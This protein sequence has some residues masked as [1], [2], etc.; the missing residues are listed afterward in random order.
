MAQN[1]EESKSQAGT[2]NTN[3]T[4]NLDGKNEQTNFWSNSDMLS[5]DF[6][7]LNVGEDALNFLSAPSPSMNSEKNIPSPSLFQPNA[8]PSIPQS[9]A[10]TPTGSGTTKQDQ[11][12]QNF[13]LSHYQN[14]LS[15]SKVPMKQATSPLSY[16]SPNTGQSGASQVQNPTGSVSPANNVPIN[17]PLHP[18]NIQK[19]LQQQPKQSPFQPPQSLFQENNGTKGNNNPC[20]H[21][22]RRQIKCITVPNLINCVQCETKGIKCTHSES[23]S[24]PTLKRNMGMVTNANVADSNNNNNKRPRLSPQTSGSSFSQ[25]IPTQSN[26]LTKQNLRKQ[27]QTPQSQ[28]PPTLQYPRSSFF[29]GSS[30]MYDNSILDR[31]RLD[32]IDQVQLSPSLSLRKVSNDVQFILR[33]DY[34]DELA[35]KA[36]K[37]VDAVENIVSPHGQSLINTYFRIIH[38]S[39]P[40]L[41]RKVFL[42][43]YSRS[44]REFSAPLLASVYYLAIQ[45]WD[46]D[47][48]LSQYPKPDLKLLYEI[49]LKSFSEV[50]DRPRLSAVQAGLLILQCRSENEN[51]WIL[52]QQVVSLAEELGLGLD[53]QNW[54]LPK[55]ERGLRRRLAWAVWIQEKWTALIESRVSHFV[56]GRN[57]L[58]R[59]VTEEDFPEHPVRRTNQSDED[60]KS[61]IDDIE[62]GKYLFKETIELSL[63][64]GE[65]LETF[66]SYNALQNITKVEQ[67]LKLAKPLQLQL[68]QWY[69]SLPTTLHMTSVKN[70]KL[71][72]NAYL[73]LSYFATEILLHRKIISSLNEETPPELIKVCRT[74]ATTRLTAVIDFVKSLR[75]EHVYAFWNSPTSS[76]FTIV[77]TFAAILYVTSPTA[78]EAQ[79]FR[80]HTS[81]YRLLLYKLGKFSK[82]AF[83]AL[84]R[85]DMLL[86]HIPGLIKEISTDQSP[87]SNVSQSP[88]SNFQSLSPMLTQHM[89]SNLPNIG[90]MPNNL[91]N[92]NNGG[93]RRNGPPVTT[94][95]NEVD[96][97]Q[98]PSG[99][100]ETGSRG[101][102]TPLQTGIPR[103]NANSPVDV[104]VG[105]SGTTPK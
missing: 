51:N 8:A 12:H 48:S 6:N 20:D 79:Q 58:V 99:L 66:Y 72:S 47:P 16:T 25:R 75:R 21:C 96:N 42:E 29:V 13:M 65:I 11:Q 45:W 49:A 77:G 59:N 23:P 5:P 64:M 88:N 105:T 69:H 46:Q 1:P 70:G 100:S 35:S 52:C 91:P 26:N 2:P 32:K 104:R 97:K 44:Y 18:E 14:L 102:P 57:W 68:R 84:K 39:F 54:K 30:S 85:I 3:I 38:P 82:N 56:L 90:N 60:Y 4:L 53:C 41:H 19:S 27:S 94:V 92:S 76:N 36:D 86:N 89:N 24:N 98:S 83:N 33:D 9:S 71:S 31:I 40:I 73:H 15:Q 55:W 101:Q 22:R 61:M 93:L 95:K 78:Q 17:H 87:L 10:P 62:N 81:V 67:V 28:P 37:L 43:K 7:F 50:T 63:I 74:A 80:E 34:T 103:S